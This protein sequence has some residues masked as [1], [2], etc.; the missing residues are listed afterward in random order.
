MGHR[1]ILLQIGLSKKDRIALQMVEE[2]EERGDLKPGQTVVEL[3]SGEN[4][5][6]L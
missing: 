6:T 1:T 3:T 4:L 5:S 2:A